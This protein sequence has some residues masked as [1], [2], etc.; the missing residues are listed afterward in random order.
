[1]GRYTSFQWQRLLICGNRVCSCTWIW[2][3]KPSEQQHKVACWF[4]VGKTELVSFDGWNN[5]HW[6]ENG[7]VCPFQML[8]LSICAKL[9]WCSYIPWNAKSTSKKNWGL[10][11]FY[12]VVSSEAALYLC[13]SIIQACMECCY[14]WVIAPCC[15]M[16]MLDELQKQVWRTVVPMLPVAY[17]PLVHFQKVAKLSL[18]CI[19]CF[20]RF[21]L[22][23]PNWYHFLILVEVPRFILIGCIIYLPPCSKSV[24]HFYCFSFCY[25]I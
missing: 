22:N 4:D 20:G 16:C 9:R 1:M 18:F 21:N 10:H 17:E 19:C 23:R 7:L 12:K 24:I 15:C 6:C 5:C 8:G 25:Y 13:N 11:L 2:P 3:T 14:V